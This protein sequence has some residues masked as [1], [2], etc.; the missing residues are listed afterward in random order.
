MHTLSSPAFQQFVLQ[1]LPLGGADSVTGSSYPAAPQLVPFYQ[2]MFSLYG[3]VSG[4]TPRRAWLSLQ[5]RRQ[6]GSGQSTEWK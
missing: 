1:Q 5:C 3:N 4:T 2:K 6:P